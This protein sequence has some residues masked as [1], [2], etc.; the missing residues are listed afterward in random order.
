MLKGCWSF[1]SPGF[2]AIGALKQIAWLVS[3]A[4][5]EAVEEV[6]RLGNTSEDWHWLFLRKCLEFSDDFSHVQ[7]TSDVGYVEGQSASG[8]FLVVEHANLICISKML[9]FYG[10][11]RVVKSGVGPIFP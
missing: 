8:R 6:A 2:I 9:T 4:R 11:L 3:V 7:L 1:F 5:V 10:N